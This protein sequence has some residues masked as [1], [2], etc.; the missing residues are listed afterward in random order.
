MTYYHYCSTDTFFNITHN[1]SIWL[2]SLSASNDTQEGKTLSKIAARLCDRL[3]YD[4][5]ETDY[6]V[7]SISGIEENTDCVGLCL[8]DKGDMLS[9]W[10]GYADDGTGVAI[11]F[12]GGFFERIMSENN[13]DRDLRLHR[14]VYD[15]AEQ[16]QLLL[17]RFASIAAILQSK[18]LRMPTVL[19]FD[20][21]RFPSYDEAVSHQRKATLKMAL[22]VIRLVDLLY[23]TKNPAFEEERESRF[24]CEVPSVYG[25][26]CNF[27]PRGAALVPYLSIP[28]PKDVDAA[29]DCVVIGPK[30]P[31]PVGVM[32]AFLNKK[33]INCPVYLSNATYR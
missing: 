28:F 4:D 9:Q 14:V 18:D 30:N 29:Y 23:A 3:G 7:R 19:T 33:G 8:S 10:R 1:Q 5:Y 26:R 31:T 24:I 2:S 27:R 13:P 15:E 6:L 32:K 25:G 20:Q 17:D 11:G 12:S 16:E 21:S 22:E